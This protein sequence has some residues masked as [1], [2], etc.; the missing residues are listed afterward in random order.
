VEAT[1]AP[2]AG[3]AQAIHPVAGPGLVSP[4][5]PHAQTHTHRSPSPPHSPPVSLGILPWIPGGCYHPKS[6]RLRLSW[7]VQVGAC[8]SHGLFGLHQLPRCL[9][10]HC[11]PQVGWLWQWAR[12]EWSRRSSGSPSP[13]IP[14][15]PSGACRVVFITKPNSRLLDR[16][17]SVEQLLFDVS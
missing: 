13:L 14:C 3:L 9:Q 12:G 17:C 2:A 5:L 4:L 6:P 10:A 15:A 11:V 8:V 1:D 7:W 16:A